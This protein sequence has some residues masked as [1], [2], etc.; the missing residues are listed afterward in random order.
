MLFGQDRIFDTVARLTAYSMPVSTRVSA[1][2]STSGKLVVQNGSGLGFYTLAGLPAVSAPPAITRQPQAA[3]S[4]SGL[5]S[6]EVGV[7]GSVPFT[8]LWQ[9]QA[10]GTG[11]WANIFNGSSYSGAQAAILQLS[12]I[13]I[14]MNGDQFRSV[15]TNAAGNVT[16]AGA[17]LSVAPLPV[18]TVP[19]ASQAALLGTTVNL[20]V[21][22]NSPVSVTYQWR[23]GGVDIPGATTSTYGIASFAS[24]DVGS[25]TVVVTNSA[26]SVTLRGRDP[27]HRAAAG[28]HGGPGEPDG[29]RGEPGGLFGHG[30]EQRGAHL[31]V[32]EERHRD[33]RGDQRDLRDRQCAGHR[34]GQLFGYRDE[35]RRHG[36]LGRSRAH[37]AAAADDHPA[38]GQPADLGW[39]PRPASRWR[40]RA[41]P[42]CPT[43]GSGCRPAVARGRT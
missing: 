7:S 5:A 14:L 10:A 12:G 40:P 18:I 37:S 1:F 41:R 21:S 29:E 2:N 43:S 36:H 24:G 25:Y 32:A 26:G 13:T 15:V 9:R 31:R 16:S 20:S 38:A 4:S 22:V 23:K 19:P 42:P 35:H 17:A 34:R 30:D 3:A 8:F 11:T 6:F 27:R 28:D 39:R 33:P